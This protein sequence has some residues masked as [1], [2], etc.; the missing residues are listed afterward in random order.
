MSDMK[1][2]ILYP[3][4]K[5]KLGNFGKFC[6]ASYFGDH[7]CVAYH[8]E[9]LEKE[10]ENVMKEAESIL[11]IKPHHDHIVTFFTLTIQGHSMYFIMKYFT[12][13]NSFLHRY[14]S[15][16]NIPHIFCLKVCMLQ[17]IICGLWFLH[18]RLGIVHSDLSTSAIFLYGDDLT[19]RV[20]YF[21]KIKDYA[22]SNRCSTSLEEICYMPPE[23]FIKHAEKTKNYDIFSFGCI[24]IEMILHTKPVPDLDF[25]EELREGEYRVISEV[26]RRDRYLK[27]IESFNL[28]KLP[29]IIKSCL[30]NKPDKRPETSVLHGKITEYKD[31]LSRG[32]RESK[33]PRSRIK[34]QELKKH[35]EK[36]VE[37]ESKCCMQFVIMHFVYILAK[38]KLQLG[39]VRKGHCQI[40][41]NH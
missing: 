6:A 40:K 29:E 28:G 12:T 17:N 30:H 5:F 9:Y 22:K 34:K 36:Y 23:L 39:A 31:T 19:A 25:L 41:W 4:Q 16:A 24:A 3:A 18:K 35:E 10:K 33:L 26:K 14:A 21:G 1:D 13:L 8:V 27:K 38:Q 7:D 37:K 11:K 20:A 32:S 2:I 15:S